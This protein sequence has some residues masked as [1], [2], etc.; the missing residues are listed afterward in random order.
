M[1]IRVRNSELLLKLNNVTSLV[2]SSVNKYLSYLEALYSDEYSFHRDA[3]EIGLTFLLADTYPTLGALAEENYQKNQRLKQLFPSKADYLSEDNFPLR[4]KK[5]CSMDLATG[6]GKSYLMF[7]LAQLALCEGLVDKVLVLCPSLT[8]EEGLTEKFNDLNSKKELADIL[9]EINPNFIQPE[10]KNA[11]ETI[12]EN[13]ICIENIHATYQRTGSSVEDSFKKEGN[14]VLVLNDEA[15]HIYSGVTDSR[16]KK[17]LD[18]LKDEEYNFRY[19]IGVTGTP[20]YKDRSGNYNQYFCDVIYRFGIKSATDWGIVKKIDY[21]TFDEY[22]E[23]KGYQDAWAVH[24][25]NIEIYG[26]NLKPLSIVVCSSIADAIIEWRALVDFMV[27]Q[28]KDEDTAIRKV[29]WVTSGFPSSEND[30][31]RIK[32]IPERDG[33]SPEKVRKEN[34]ASLKEVDFPENPVEWIVSVAMLTEGWDVKNVFQVIP[35]KQKA[36]NSKLLIAQ[37][38]GR[39]LR[40][41]PIIKEKGIE[42]LLK[43]GNHEKWSPEIQNLYNEVAEIENRLSWG[44]DQS[45][46]KYAFELYNLRYEPLE[47]TTESKEKKAEFSGNFGFQDQR[48]K[49]EYKQEYS[50]SHTIQYVFEDKEI[51]ETNI[52]VANL[53]SYLKD[54]DP[55]ITKKWTKANLKTSIEKEL[56]DKG[57]ETGFLSRKNYAKAQQAFGPLFREL[58]KKVPRISNNPDNLFQISMESIP[59]QSFSENSLRSN[60]TLFYT[61]TTLIWYKGE[62]KTLF[63]ALTNIENDISKKEQA[64]ALLEDETLKATI[65]EKIEELRIMQAKLIRKEEVE[66]NTPL[67]AVYVSYKPEIEFTKSLFLNSDKIESFIKSADKGFYF[68]PYSYKPETT[69]KT[70]PKHDNF[71]PDFLLKIKGTNDIVVVEIKAEKDDSKKNQAKYRDG[72]KHFKEL[73]AKLK[74]A[75]KPDR[76]YFKFLSPESSD[77][78]NFFQSIKDGN[79]KEWK[80]ILMEQLEQTD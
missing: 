58:S 56:T 66:F 75:D 19:I 76:Y 39:G 62:E 3:V 43:V 12:L 2:K 1:A 51:F 9:R 28:G 50:I 73:N 30:K 29:I 15:H 20:Y 6:T 63:E 47:T 67:N 68:F 10:I 49:A 33:L 44:Y 60:G 40:V 5:S 78:A 42:S 41:P 55:E 26:E 71:N 18:F 24:E 48:K 27:S 53:Y 22:K 16:D 35:H 77:I 11:N 57:Y 36:F 32:G 72:N 65:D 8:I 61:D 69:A 64:K 17:W 37:V 25:K 34:L 13:D 80:S 70:H 54:K 45:R 74:Q 46:K 79:Y 38:L 4:D 59:N 52:A 23:D 21:K 31:N 7:G 14:R